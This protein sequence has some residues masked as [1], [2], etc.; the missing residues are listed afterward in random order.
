MIFAPGFAAAAAV[1]PVLAID[2]DG[3]LLMNLQD[4]TM[5]YP[6]LTGVYETRNSLYLTSLFGNQFG[7]LDKRD[8]L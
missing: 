5:T 4:T 2:G 3:R 1:G 6:A 8:L 7:R